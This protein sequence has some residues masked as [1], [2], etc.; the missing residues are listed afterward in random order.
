MNTATE[1]TELEESTSEFREQVY[2]AFKAS[3]D[4]GATVREVSD[5]LGGSYKNVYVACVTSLKSRLRKI[6]PAQYCVSPASSGL[7]ASASLRETSS[8]ARVEAE[9]FALPNTETADLA[10]AVVEPP[11]EQDAEMGAQLTEQYQSYAQGEQDQKMRGLFLGVMG[12]KL[13]A[14]IA[15]N[16]SRGIVRTG[17]AA[18]KGKGMKGWLAQYAPKVTTSNLYDWMAIAEG[19]QNHFRLA[20]DVDIKALL[21]GDQASV[22]PKLVKTADRIRKYLEGKSRTQLQLAFAHR[23]TGGKQE[24]TK[25]PAERDPVA[26]AVG[27]WTPL[28]RLLAEEGLNEK[29]WGHLPKAQLDQLKGL[30]V[31]LS[32]AIR[33]EA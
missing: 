18:S 2:E 12:L 24:T 13:R 4:A 29:S 30:L 16:S 28:L 10:P 32:K 26:E 33:N 9:Q 14:H 22:S 15:N 6:G 7:C 1:T 5:A 25:E 8:P 21:S 31:D 27:I 11:T 19:V 23:S 20:A 17:G 3:G